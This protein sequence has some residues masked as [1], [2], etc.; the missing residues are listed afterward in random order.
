MAFIAP[1]EPPVFGNVSVNLTAITVHLEPV[2]C[3]Q[4][5]SIIESYN[6]IVNTSVTN[7]IRNL[8]VN[9]GARETTVPVTIDKL[10][11]NTDYILEVRAVNVDGL[12]SPS[13]N[14]TM[15]TSL[16]EGRSSLIQLLKW[17][18]TVFFL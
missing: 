13:R 8:S 18:Y 5:N 16:P 7:N 14:I 12:K 6:V 2:S 17:N 10:S 3:T 15:K 9:I 11:P 1:D 4:Q